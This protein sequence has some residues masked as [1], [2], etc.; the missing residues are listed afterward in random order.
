[1]RHPLHCAHEIFRAYTAGDFFLSYCLNIKIKRAGSLARPAPISFSSGGFLP[2]PRLAYERSPD[3]ED[4]ERESDHS[5]A[6]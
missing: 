4:S 5:N 6:K 3:N 1:M 2:E